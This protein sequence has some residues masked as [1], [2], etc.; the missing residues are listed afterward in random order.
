M[1]AL[2][3][4]AS[5]DDGAASLHK[6]LD[7]HDGSVLDNVPGYLASPDLADG[8]KIVGHAFGGQQQSV[9]SNLASRTGLD[10]ATIGK[11]LAMA[12]PLVLGQLGKM[13]K[14]GGLDS[15][16]LSKALG[17]VHKANESANPDLMGVLTGALDSNKDGG[18]FDDLQR[19]AGKFLKP[20][21]SS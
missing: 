16:G 11:L 1:T 21:P 6:A 5:S 15:D 7:D 9:E 17:E 18:I 14:Q 19:L 2:A 3:H 12:A 8:Q 4:N 10:A 13:Q 20:K